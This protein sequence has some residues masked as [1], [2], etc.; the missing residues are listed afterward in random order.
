MLDS[1][2][3]QYRPRMAA[4]GARKPTAGAGRDPNGPGFPLLSDSPS[5]AA[6]VPTGLGS[7]TALKQKLEFGKGERSEKRLFADTPPGPGREAPRG[8]EELRD[9]DSK[10]RFSADSVVGG[11]ASTTSRHAGAET[12]PRL[13]AAPARLRSEGEK[14]RGF[15]C[16]SP[17]CR[18][19]GRGPSSQRAPRR[20]YQVLEAGGAMWG[21]ACKIQVL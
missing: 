11:T 1:G 9:R 16:P 10:R 6:I 12:R 8:P 14:W 17:L 20:A 2:K 4:L 21:G 7:R 15:G 3:A 19:H 13:R 5:A 18:A